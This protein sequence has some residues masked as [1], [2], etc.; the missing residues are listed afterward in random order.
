METRVDSAAL[1]DNLLGDPASRSVHVYLPPEKNDSSR[2]FPLLVYLASFT[3]SSLKMTA[4]KAFGESFPQRLERLVQNGEMGPAVVAFPDCFTSLGGNQYVNSEAVGNWEDFLV[5]DLLPQLTAEFPIEPSPR[6]RAVLGFSSGGYG[7]LMQGL[8]HGDQWGAVACHSGDIGFD[9]LLKPMF[10][11]AARLLEENDFSCEKLLENF[12]NR[13]KLD[14]RELETVSLLAMG[15]TYDPDPDQAFGIRLP[16]DA[17]TCELIEQRWSRWLAHDPLELIDT[18]PGRNSLSQLRDLY[19][20][21]GRQDQ[22]HLQYGARR[23]VRK[24][25]AYEIAHHYEEF[26]DNHSGIDYR[27]DVS[28]PLLYRA[29]TSG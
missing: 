26:N 27:L 16:F 2:R 4:W 25:Q 3:N 12:R 11:R 23:L 10:P 21:C 9:L 19:L 6:R 28:L 14:G 1:Q 20:D 22:Y 5:E 18:L 29:V 15:A 13:I 7:A 8:R 17:F 24:L